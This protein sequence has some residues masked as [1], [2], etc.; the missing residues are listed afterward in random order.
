MRVGTAPA[1][2]DAR[3]LAE[4]TEPSQRRILPSLLV[5]RPTEDA[6]RGYVGR[7]RPYESRAGWSGLTVSRRFEPRRE[8]ALMVFA[9]RGDQTSRNNGQKTR[10]ARL[11]T[12][13]GRMQNFRDC[14]WF[15]AYMDRP[16]VIP[17]VVLNRMSHCP[18]ARCLSVA[19]ARP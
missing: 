12:H 1:Y 9:G 8:S 11:R 2:G 3:H 4:L 16:H 14:Q 5:D 17:G 19:V 13:A 6:C 18:P 15:V 7:W 10:I